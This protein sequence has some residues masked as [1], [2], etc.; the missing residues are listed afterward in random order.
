MKVDFPIDP[1]HG[2]DDMNTIPLYGVSWDATRRDGRPYRACNSW[3]SRP[4]AEEV[5]A[6]KLAEGANPTTKVTYCG[7]F[8]F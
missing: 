5:Y 1:K 4:K 8:A 7:G 6:R 3:T 2:P